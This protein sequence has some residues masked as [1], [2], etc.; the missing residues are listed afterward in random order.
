MPA[1]AA[2]KSTKLLFASGFEQPVT[3]E[4]KIQNGNWRFPIRGADDG[5]GWQ[6]DLPGGTPH[7]FFP[8]VPGSEAR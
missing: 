4:P 5:F 2:A 6:S 1:I 3:V 8:I 7:A